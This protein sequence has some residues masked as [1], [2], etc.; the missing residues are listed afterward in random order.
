MKPKGLFFA[1]MYFGLASLNF[2]GRLPEFQVFS[3][4]YVKNSRKVVN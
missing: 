3:E 2:V 4:H 1:M